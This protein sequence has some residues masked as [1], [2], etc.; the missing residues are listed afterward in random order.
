MAQILTW[1]GLWMIVGLPH[2][3][4]GL[5]LLQLIGAVVMIVGIALMILGTPKNQ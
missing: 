2:L 1:L 4:G 5:A 3:G